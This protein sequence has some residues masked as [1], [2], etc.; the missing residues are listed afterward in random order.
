MFEGCHPGT[1]ELL[2]RSHGR[3]AVPAFDVVL[4]P[5]KSVSVLYGLGDAVTGRNT[6]VRVSSGLPLC[7]P[8]FAHVDADRQGRS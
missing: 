4:R 8:A 5:T 3:G 2:G 6:S 1:G 7:G